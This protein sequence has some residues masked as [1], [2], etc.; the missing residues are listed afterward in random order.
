MKLEID[1][2]DG[3]RFH[4]LFRRGDGWGAILACE[5]L[6]W[7]STYRQNFIDLRP[8]EPKF[9]SCSCGDY[10]YASAQAAID[11]TFE[12][13]KLV[14]ARLD[15]LAPPAKPTKSAEPKLNAAAVAGI[16]LGELDI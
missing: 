12:K 16:N 5:P 15:G 1:L 10:G 8:P 2:P 6:Y 7:P 13:L 11:G 4:G 14:M 3:V 9:H